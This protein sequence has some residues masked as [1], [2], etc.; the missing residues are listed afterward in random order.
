MNSEFEL[1]P[2]AASKVAGSVDAI[3]IFM[4]VLSAIMTIAIAST[5]IFF[6]IKYRRDAVVNRDQQPTS[7]TRELTWIAAAVPVLLFIF[8][9]GVKVCF[10]LVRVP[11]GAMPINVVAKQ[12]MWK[13]QHADGRREIDV[14]HVP[15]GRPVALTMVS[16]D[17]IHSFYV[18]AFRVKQDVLPGRYTT[19]WFQATKPGNYRLYCAEYCG[20]N[21]SRMIGKIVVQS[22]E[23][24]EKW[25]AGESVGDVSPVSA[26]ERLFGQFQC[27][28]CHE[29]MQGPNRGPSLVGIFGKTTP[30]A[31]GDTATIDEQ[32]LRE[33]ILRPAAKVV[34]GF[35]P[36]MPPY[37][38]Q[39]GEEH[40]LE[41]I[42]YIKSLESSASGGSL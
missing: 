31:S 23:D 17:V 1:F 12:W 11:Q 7:I 16:Q 10:E 14:L 20:T 26:G 9:W 29:R 32:Y 13:F 25:L 22:P 33:S 18:P 4:V 41:L 34:A 2:E 38:G 40:L 3:Y 35:Q 15:A 39:I 42:A 27:V 19:L 28:N 36:I 6:A 5:L 24:F 30:L 21:H 8:I 37:E